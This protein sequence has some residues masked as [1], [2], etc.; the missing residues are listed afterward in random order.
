[1]PL[2]AI[3]FWFFV[4]LR[5]DRFYI[6]DFHTALSCQAWG[7]ALHQPGENLQCKN[8]Q[9]GNGYRTPKTLSKSKILLDYFK[10]I[11]RLMIGGF[12]QFIFEKVVFGN[13]LESIW[14]GKLFSRKWRLSSKQL[15]AVRWTPH[16]LNIPPGSLPTAPCNEHRRTWE[17]IFPPKDQKSSFKKQRH[18]RR[19]LPINA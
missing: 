8:D 1:M 18:R 5:F 11:L 3:F 15:L 2:V 19:I 7:R 12:R 9:N 10:L 4:R 16:F 14:R 13:I 6:V 17:A